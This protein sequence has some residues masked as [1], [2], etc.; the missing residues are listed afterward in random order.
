MTHTPDLADDAD[1]VSAPIAP[2]YFR[3]VLGHFL[4]GVTVVSAVF[5]GE[6]VGLTV[7]SF[8]SASL[9]PPLVGFCA[10]KTSRSWPG[11]KE[12]GDFCVNVLAADQEALCRQ[13][14]T[15]SGSDKFRGVGWTMT[16]GGAPRLD[17]VLAWIDCR[18]EAVH[19]AGDHEICI[20]R[21]KRLSVDHG[22]PPLLFFRGQ[23]LIS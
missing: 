2:E 16:D 8:F 21:V 15:A 20:G 1:L 12:V 5:Q 7:G 6:P 10:A 19:D 11:I 9:D 3:R 4:T 14:A 13:F 23:Y 18:I 22:R 17:R